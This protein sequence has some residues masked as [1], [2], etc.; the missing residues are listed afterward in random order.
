MINS[1]IFEICAGHADGFYEATGKTIVPAGRSMLSSLVSLS[2]V[3]SV[4]EGGPVSY[5]QVLQA[6]T[7]DSVDGPSLHTAAIGAQIDYLIPLVS[8]HI[9]F[10]QNNVRGKVMAFHEAM[11]EEISRQNAR[12]PYESFDIVQVSEP[13]LLHNADFMDM[14]KLYADPDSV[15]PAF[16][17]M[18]ALS[19]EELSKAMAVTG[20]ANTQVSNFIGSVG[21][22]W[23]LDLWAT[24]FATGNMGVSGQNEGQFEGGIL[25]L[26]N[27]PALQRMN[28]S[29]AV[30]LISRGLMEDPVE[31]ASMSLGDWR[32]AMDK[33]SRFAAAQFASGARFVETTLRDE[34]V[35]IG[36]S[37]N[38][39][40]I[41]VY[42]PMYVKYME[43]GGTVE[44]I[45]GA[46]LAN[47]STTYSLS[48]LQSRNTDF[49]AVWKN[50]QVTNQS[51][52]DYRSLMQLR[53]TASSLFED[54][55]KEVDSDELA[56]I[57]HLGN[58][59]DGMRAQAA[60][61]IE[62]M[63]LAG[64]RRAE[65]LALTLVAGIRFAHTPAESFLRNMMEAEQAGCK[66]AQEAAAYAAALY[67][68]DYMASEMAI[69]TG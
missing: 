65:D 28:N 51:S 25:G 30:F 56:C 50:F 5:A 2:T 34:S 60:A 4:P 13:E 31:G 10:V 48:E 44:D 67:V 53:S 7:Q 58:S 62:G 52:M 64:L 42:A 63:S 49:Q 32:H 23:L 12:T 36:V 22:A 24:Y 8:S 1:K 35:I 18:P 26:Q 29:L 33:I 15:I 54:V 19:F 14:V 6:Q 11:E 69:V 61:V 46:A 9:A 43:E 16:T 21:E 57:Q 39:R 37:S 68:A 45:L 41:S 47:S 59:F 40:R 66:S 20:S 3:G 17:Q 38:Q 27:L 55:L